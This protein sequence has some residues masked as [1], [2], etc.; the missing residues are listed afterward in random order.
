MTTSEQRLTKKIEQLEKKVARL[1]VQKSNLKQ[2]VDKLKTQIVKKD[3]AYKKLEEKLKQDGKIKEPPV[4]YFHRNYPQL[5]QEFGSLCREWKLKTMNTR[6]TVLAILRIIEP[7]DNGVVEYTEKDVINYIT[8]LKKLGRT[9]YMQNPTLAEYYEPYDS[10]IL[11]KHYKMIRRNLLQWINPKRAKAE[12]LGFKTGD[13]TLNG[14]KLTP[15][16]KTAVCSWEDLRNQKRGVAHVNDTV[17]IEEFKGD[18]LVR[19]RE[20][21]QLKLGSAYDEKAVMERM[22]YQADRYFGK[23]SVMEQIIDSTPIVEEDD[24]DI[25][26]S[27]FKEVK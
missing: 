3:L 10:L 20:R 14:I 8:L 19:E 7:D 23:D 25:D 26:I 13:T 9:K 5:A 27:E 21:R 16:K 15:A 11:F 6:N 12:Q 4:K 24:D 17:N 18:D 22:K 2:R 1:E